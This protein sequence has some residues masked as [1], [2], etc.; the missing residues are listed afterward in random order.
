MDQ[1]SASKAVLAQLR[2][3]VISHGGQFGAVYQ[4]TFVPE[5]YYRADKKLPDTEMTSAERAVHAA[6][7]LYAVHQQS[8]YEPMH[9]NGGNRPGAA[10]ALLRSE[11]MSEQA[12]RRRFDS[13]LMAG[14]FAELSQHLRTLVRLLRDSSISMDYGRLTRDL[15]EW[16]FDFAATGVRIQW[17]RDFENTLFQNADDEKEDTE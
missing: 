15:Y 4:K 6:M 13:L 7:T 3:A 2:R 5:T 10:F 9:D 12:V 8:L 14:N 1:T 16:Q 11:G 17:S